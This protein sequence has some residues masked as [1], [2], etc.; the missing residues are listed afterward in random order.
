MFA[1]RTNWE[2]T[3]NKITTILE[4]L[5]KEGTAIFDLTE[6]NPTRCGFSYPQSEILKELS[7][8]QN[9]RYAPSPRGNLSARKAICDY[10]AD[11]NIA[12]DPEQIFLTAG[13]SEAY[14]FLF[15]LL[16]EP[17]DKVLFPNPSYPLFQFLFDLNDLQYTPYPLTYAPHHGWQVNVEGF[18]EAVAADTKAVVF[19]NP[20][21]PT[22]SFVRERELARINAICRSR[23]LAMI[24]DEVFLDYAFEESAEPMSLAGNREVL[25]FVLSGI[26]KILGLPQMKLG[27]IVVN[28]PQDLMRD[29][30]AR[31]EIIGDTYLSVNTPVQNAL[32]RWFEL[33]PVIQKEILQRVER[34]R[35]FLFHHVSSQ[36]K[37]KSSCLH[38]EGGWYAILKLGPHYMEEILVEELLTEDQV[39]VHPGYFFDFEEEPYL[40]LSLLPTEEIFQEGVRRLLKRIAMKI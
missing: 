13:T 1:K 23:N 27:W 2:L 20:N 10:Y 19:V 26:S 5:R 33:R 22:G 14:S 31:L 29:A 36:A 21:N 17:G 7:S 18:Y 6:S 25:T 12:V 8:S 40:V 9:L 30:M 3:T 34:N 28:G 11:K 39:F 24:S 4:S 15:R 38:C 16:A 37:E 32:P 35:A